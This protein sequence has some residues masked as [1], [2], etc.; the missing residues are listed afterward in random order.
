M[1]GI[2][3]FSERLKEVR[4]NMGLSQSDFAKLIGITQ[5]SLSSYEKCVSKPPLDIAIKISEKCN[6]SL[7]WLCGLSDRITNNKLFRNYIDI[8]DIFFDI[9][10]IAHLDVYPIEIDFYI[11]KDCGDQPFN[12]W[13]IAFTDKHLNEFLA[14]WKKMRHLRAEGIIDNELYALW[15]E[16]T[17]N[18]YNIPIEPEIL[19]PLTPTDTPAQDS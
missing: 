8:I 15:I 4:T 3:I 1:A 13:G 11:Q 9:M 18:K 5:Q 19:T 12:G 17:V 10:N 2:E 14:D 6:I 7:S 16:K